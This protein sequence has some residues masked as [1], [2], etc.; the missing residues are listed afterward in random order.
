MGGIAGY[1]KAMTKW[2]INKS[3]EQIELITHGFFAVFTN[4]KKFDHL[5]SVDEDGVNLMKSLGI[6]SEDMI[7]D[8]ET[9]NPF[10]GDLN[11]W[12]GIFDRYY[13]RVNEKY[14]SFD[15]YDIPRE[16]CMALG[17]LNW[18]KGTNAVIGVGIAPSADRVHTSPD[19]CG[20]QNYIY[21][22]DGDW[23]VVCNNGVLDEEYGETEDDRIPLPIPLD[24]VSQHCNCPNNTCYFGVSFTDK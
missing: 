15:Y 10:G 2:K 3:I 13:A 5:N 14:I 11:I 1:S 21:V 20:L 7:V 24:I 23:L 17:S 6:I 4:Q 18:A 8:G 22:N 16:A 12:A 19:E 9:K